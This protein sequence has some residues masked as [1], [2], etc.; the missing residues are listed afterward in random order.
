MQFSIARLPRVEFGA[1]SLD[2]LPAILETFAK[3][4][5]FVTGKQSL[6][7]SPLWPTLLAQLNSKNIDCLFATIS[8][9]PSPQLVD[10]VSAKHRNDNIDCVIGLGGGSALDAAKAIA[11]L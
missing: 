7:Q 9:E 10:Q 6:S 3:R 8:N 1:G 2:K 5:L 4:V 11:G